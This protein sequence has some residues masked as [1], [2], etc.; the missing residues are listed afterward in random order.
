MNLIKPNNNIKLICAQIRTD[1]LRRGAASL[2][3]NYIRNNFI[4]KDEK[5]YNIFLTTYLSQIEID[6]KEEFGEKLFLINGT[7]LI[8]TMIKTSIKKIHLI[9]SQ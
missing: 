1:F 4:K 5:K 8:A 2:F 9:C 6:G 3:W 7:I